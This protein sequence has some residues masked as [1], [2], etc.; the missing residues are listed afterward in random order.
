[1][2]AGLST[3]KWIDYP[4]QEE[5]YEAGLERQSLLEAGLWT[6]SFEIPDTSRP[7]EYIIYSLDFTTDLDSVLDSV[8]EEYKWFY[9][10][11]MN[12]ARF[13]KSIFLV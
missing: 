7:G 5:N 3:P 10:T 9:G 11:W 4:G 1:M 2:I 12:S 8:K 13:E 6:A